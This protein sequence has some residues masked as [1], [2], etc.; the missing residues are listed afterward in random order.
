M[1][2][3]GQLLVANYLGQLWNGKV[4]DSSFARHV[5]SSFPIGVG[6]VVLGW[7]KAL[8]GV[9]AGSRLLLVVPPVDGYGSAGQP[10]GGIPA[11]ATL[12]FVVDV[13]G[14]YSASTTPPP[15]TVPVHT[16]VDGVAVSWPPGGLPVVHV[17]KGYVAP[18]TPTVT[19]LSRGTGRPVTSGLVVL[20]YVVVNTKTGKVVDSTWQTGW[21]DGENAGIKAMPSLLDKLVG[22]PVGTRVLLRTTKSSQG[23]FVFALE[24]LA[25]PSLLK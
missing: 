8:V 16:S 7:D 3:K 23:T 12:A 11:N 5:A 4:F 19:V 17:S 25:Q 22:L 6:K 1:V 9:H 24:T 10:T 15:G 13:I 18:K 14:S 20:Q 21:P 2:K